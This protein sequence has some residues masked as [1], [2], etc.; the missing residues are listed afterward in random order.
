MTVELSDSLPNNAAFDDASDALRER[1]PTVSAGAFV[2]WSVN[3]SDSRQQIEIIDGRLH[4][5]ARHQTPNRKPMHAMPDL[6]VPFD[7]QICCSG[8]LIV[9]VI[10]FEFSPMTNSCNQ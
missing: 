5:W 4:Q 6:R 10:R 1:S 9:A 8:W 2:F 3:L 7:I